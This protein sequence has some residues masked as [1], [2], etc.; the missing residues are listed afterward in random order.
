V[1]RSEKVQI[2]HQLWKRYD[3]TQFG[4][5]PK[6]RITK[7]LKEYWMKKAVKFEILT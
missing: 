6:Q 1:V 3:V 2:G 5:C 4:K 7:K